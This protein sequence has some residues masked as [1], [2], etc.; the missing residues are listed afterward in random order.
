MWAAGAGGARV[1]AV[2]GAGARRVAREARAGGHERR[3]HRLCAA[4]VRTPSPLSASLSENTV[5]AAGRLGLSRAER[6]ATLVHWRLIINRS[7]EKLA[8]FFVLCDK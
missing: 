2:G 7:I 8:S 4:A 1:G 3:A 5:W 6:G